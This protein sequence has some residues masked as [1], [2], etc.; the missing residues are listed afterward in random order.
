MKIKNRRYHLKL[1][2]DTSKVSGWHIK[3]FVK[4]K[5]KSKGMIVTGKRTSHERICLI[6]NKHKNNE[7]ANKRY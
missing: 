1:L 4:E 5:V 7:Y 2:H 6:V 3:D